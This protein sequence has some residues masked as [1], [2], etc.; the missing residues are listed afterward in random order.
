MLEYLPRSEVS[1]LPGAGLAV[2]WRER[3]REDGYAPNL[4]LAERKRLFHHSRNE[5][6]FSAWR[7]H[8]VIR[9]CTFLQ[10]STFVRTAAAE[11]RTRRDET[12]S[13]WLEFLLG[14]RSGDL[15]V[16]VVKR[17][18]AHREVDPALAFASVETAGRV[19]ED[20]PFN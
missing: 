18:I 5:R 17:R 9:A 3:K 7:D 11:G 16:R 2:G 1:H 12:Y 19:T 15:F 13:E 14:E 10:Q 4:V 6:Y 20:A 8:L